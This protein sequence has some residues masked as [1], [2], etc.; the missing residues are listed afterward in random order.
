MGYELSHAFLHENGISLCGWVQ[1][2]YLWRFISLKN[3]KIICIF[4]KYT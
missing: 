2:L 1:Q 3:M 4:T